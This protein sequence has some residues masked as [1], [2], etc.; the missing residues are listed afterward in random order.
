M[1]NSF[2]SEIGKKQYAGCIVSIFL[3][4]KLIFQKTSNSNLKKKGI[5]NLKK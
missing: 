2:Y 3:G 5:K 4:D 1:T